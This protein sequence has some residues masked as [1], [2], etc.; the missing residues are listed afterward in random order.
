MK[1]LPLDKIDVYYDLALSQVDGIGAKSL[2]K[3]VAHFGSSREVFRRDLA[4]LVSAP[5]MN[6]SRAEAIASFS[7]FDR[8]D[9]EMRFADEN[10]IELLSFL[11]ARYPNRLK[12]CEDGPAVLFV[13]GEAKL[14]AGRMLSIVG[15]RR[16]TGYGKSMAR[17][18]VEAV[19]PHGVTV[20]SGLAYGVDI[21][22]HRACVDLGVPT[23]AVLGHGLHE[24]YPVSHTRYA[25]DI[26]EHGGALVSEFVAGTRPDRENFPQ[27]NRIVAGMSDATV[28][29]ESGKSGGSMITASLASEYNRDVFAVP[30]RI[31]DPLSEGCNHLIATKKAKLLTSPAQ[32]LSEMGWLPSATATKKN[33]Q[34]KIFVD[35]SPE[36]EKILGLLREKTRLQIDDLGL[37]MKMPTSRLLVLLLNLELNG[38]VRSLPGK[39][40]ETC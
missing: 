8:V 3:L 28:V 36:D 25:L 30:G 40:Y 21:E 7:G 24:V 5:G 35:L 27:R 32:L 20:V 10:G 29:V 15:T 19:A 34:K 26:V 4:E 39:V 16:V 6:I 33:I 2:K 1:D 13:K 9:R 18:I 17:K 38:L 31:D 11:D 14:A 22:A 23:I 12:H 37:E